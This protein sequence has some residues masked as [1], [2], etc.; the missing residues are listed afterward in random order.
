M[1]FAG[2]RLTA[3]LKR[4]S[5]CKGRHLTCL[6]VKNNPSGRINC[7]VLL[8]CCGVSQEGLEVSYFKSHGGSSGAP[9]ALAATARNASGSTSSPLEKII[10][11]LRVELVWQ[12]AERF[13]VE[14]WKFDGVGESTSE[15]ETLRG[16]GGN[17]LRKPFV[18]PD[19]RAMCGDEKP[20]TI[21]D[22][23]LHPKSWSSRPNSR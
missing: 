13:G 19:L 9:S 7:L 1:P 2:K 20:R 17:A 4:R 22:M 21:C 14:Q 5:L 15:L 11:S 23:G 10:A 3:L 8:N 12:L 16:E 18:K 6:R